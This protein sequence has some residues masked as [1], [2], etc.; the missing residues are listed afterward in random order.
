MKSIILSWLLAVWLFLWSPIARFFRNEYKR[1]KGRPTALLKAIKKA[2][3]EHLKTGKQYKVYFLENKY[4]ILNRMDIQQKKHESVFH[5]HIN[6]TKLHPIVF[7]DT[8]L[9]FVSTFAYELLRTKYSKMQLIKL[10]I[11]QPLNK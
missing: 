2:R 3:K 11:V 10:G 4:Q 1:Y 6:V 5:R 7:F 9:G 8:Q